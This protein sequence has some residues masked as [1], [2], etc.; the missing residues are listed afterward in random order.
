MKKPFLYLASQSPRRAEILKQLK[1]PFQAIPSLYE[2][3][4]A[5]NS[6]ERPSR[7]VLRHAKGKVRL[8]RIPH[9]KDT[10]KALILGADT[11]IYFQ[12]QTLGKPAS[13]EAAEK[14]LMRMRGKSHFVYTG[15][16]LL[17]PGTGRVF[18]G[19]EKSRVLFHT[20]EKEKIKR[21]VKE[22]HALDK[23]GAY[24]IQM[25]PFI[26]KRFTGSRTNIIGLPG[27]LLLKLLRKA[28]KSC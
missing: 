9:S 19:Y 14:L 17:D 4:H 11:L 21:Y 27:E 1:I 28:V 6:K 7:T 18:S 22:I 10:R 12:G 20:W 13:Y 15:V 5:K 3:I 24:A 2:E 8:A 23:A 16:A 26:V 25:K